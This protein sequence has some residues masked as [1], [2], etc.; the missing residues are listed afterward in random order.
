MRRAGA[1]ARRGWA[2]PCWVG[3]AVESEILQ[4]IE[5]RR[6]CQAQILLEPEY[7]AVRAVDTLHADVDCA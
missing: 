1:R 3:V 4:Q 6:S 2:S 5:N 7:V